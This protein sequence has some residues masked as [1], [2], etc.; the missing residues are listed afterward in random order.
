MAL[1]WEKHMAIIDGNDLN[2]ILFGTAADDIINGLGGHDTI[3]GAGGND[4]IAGGGLCGL[5]AGFLEGSNFEV[6]A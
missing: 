6:I 1:F 4:F 2:N 3:N 5:G